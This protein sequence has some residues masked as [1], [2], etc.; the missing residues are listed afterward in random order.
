MAS[1]KRRTDGRW[2]A[3]WREY[4]GGPERSKH[5]DR[6]ID[7]EQHLVK[8]QHDLLTGAYVDPTKARVTVREFYEVWK[9]RQPWR[10]SSRTAV[11]T[12]FA[13]HILP[14]FEHRPLGSLR[15]GNIE[16]WAAG[17]TVA[18]STA[19]VAVQHFSTMLSGAVGD[20]LLASNPA[21]GAKRPRVETAPVVPF[22]LD[23]LERLRAAAPEWFR[24]ALT[25]G[26]AC[27]LRQGEA[28]GVTVDRIDFLRRTL[29]VDRQLVTPRGGAPFLGP[30]KTARSVRTVPLA[31][32][33]VD[34]LAEHLAAHGTG[35]DGFVLHLEGRPVRR[36]RFGTTWRVLRDR[37]KLPNARF[38]DT[39]HTY[40]STLLS[41]GVSV[42]AAA[43]YL[44]HTPAM[45]LGT[46]AHLV[47]ADHDRA[48]EVIDGA[49]N[50]QPAAEV[51]AVAEGSRTRN[52]RAN[53]RRCADLRK[54]PA[55][56]PSGQFPRN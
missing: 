23:E 40:A 4:P 27:G 56:A 49:F 18:P 31:T 16:D 53:P 20:G 5:F 37:A 51:E 33:A 50:A 29:T 45:L 52:G 9:S 39:R 8:M 7:A 13:T 17:L 1:V 42:A 11:E 30:P 14:T 19:R 6:K 34:Q 54:R 35:A 46:Y 25:L 3:R 15:R 47:R 48:R 22:T 21:R 43:E 44:G 10:D 12:T 26:A 28:T 55:E 2:R 32:V 38:H 41:G 36:Q 24:V